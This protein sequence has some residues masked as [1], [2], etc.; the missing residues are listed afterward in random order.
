MLLRPWQDGDIDSWANMEAD[1]RV[2]QYLLRTEKRE[3]AVAFATRMR[4]SLE[5]DGFGSWVAEIKGGLHFA[6]IIALQEVPINEY[7]TPAKEV[8]W[9][10]RSEAWGKGYATEGARAAREFARNTLAWSEIVAMT[11]AVNLL[12]THSFQ[13]D[14]RYASMFSIA[15]AS[16]KSDCLPRLA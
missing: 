1:D 6:G 13:K 10:F 8:G 7:F 3:E 9:I 15:C 2:M 14:T 4:R 12:T 16:Y 5:S 11:A